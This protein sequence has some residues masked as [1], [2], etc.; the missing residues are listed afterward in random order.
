[1][2]GFVDVLKGLYVR[3]SDMLGFVDVLKGL[4]V[5]QSDMLGFVD[6]LGDLYYMSVSLIC[7]TYLCF[8]NTFTH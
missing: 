1:M 4:Y 6:V 5:R 8:S 7:T 2:L 3:Q